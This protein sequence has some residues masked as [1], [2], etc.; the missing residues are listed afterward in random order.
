LVSQ[1]VEAAKLKNVNILK[2]DVI[3]TAFPS[4]TFDIVILLGVVPAPMLS[5]SLVLSEIYRVLKTH[6]VLSIWPSIPGLRKSI[7]KSRLFLMDNKKAGVLNFSK[8]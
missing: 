3:H 1:K 4:D 7:L 2:R 5:L 6:G 8:E